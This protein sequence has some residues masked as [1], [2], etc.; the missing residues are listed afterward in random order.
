MNT[1]VMKKKLMILTVLLG[2][3]L[4]ANAATV[5]KTYNLNFNGIEVSSKFDIQLIRSAE[6]SVVIEVD[7]E[8][9]PYLSV[10]TESGILKVR[11][12]KLPVKMKIIKDAFKMTIYTPMVNFIDISGACK[13]N[14]LDEFSLGMNNFRASISGA[15][16]VTNLKIKSIDASIKVSGASKV[17]LDGEFADFEA[18]VQG[19]SKLTFNGRSSDFDAE[20]GG[21]SELIVTG[22][23]DDVDIEVK[24]A[25]RAEFVGQ[26]E[27]LNAEIGG[28]SRL[29]A[30]EFPVMSARLEIKGASS[31][32]VDASQ[33]L[34]ADVSGASSCRYRDRAGLRLNPMIKGGSSFKTL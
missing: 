16:A 17:F 26:G 14:C 23:M 10:T 22:L 5:T 19:A 33:S 28:A 24:G 11:F 15:S 6:H 34:K 8:Y 21:S 31:A 1:A 12:K 13:L 2:L 30:E 29:K 25:S 27:Q 18:D 9:A 20:V 4:T 3:C 32:T 7:A